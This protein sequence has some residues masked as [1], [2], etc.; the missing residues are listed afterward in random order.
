MTIESGTSIWPVCGLSPMV[1]PAD[2]PSKVMKL[3]L[4][5]HCLLLLPLSVMILCW[6]FGGLM[7]VVH[8]IL[9][10]IAVILLG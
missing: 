9:S 1:A 2:L 5:I 7:A 3:F 10:S 6:F 4:F 8:S